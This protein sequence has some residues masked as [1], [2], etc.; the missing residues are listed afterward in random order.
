MLQF[1][2]KRQQPQSGQRQRGFARARLTHDAQG[3]PGHDFKIGALH[4]HK[5]PTLEP[6]PKTS[7]RRGVNHAQPLGVHHGRRLTLSA[8]ATSRTG[9]LAI[10]RWV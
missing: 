8:L 9:L 6:A 4:R 2:L 7:Q 1:T 10:R 5:F 3:L